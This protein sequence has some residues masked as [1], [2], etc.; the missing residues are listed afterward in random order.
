MHAL[1]AVESWV[2]F[3]LQALFSGAFSAVKVHMTCIEHNHKQQ[4]KSWVLLLA[5]FLAL[6]ALL[7]AL[8]LALLALFLALFQHYKC[9]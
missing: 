5:L 2:P 8:F 3:L 6:L 4:Q 9:T 1:T 7:L